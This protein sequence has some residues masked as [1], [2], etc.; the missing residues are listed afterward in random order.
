MQEIE[1]YSLFRIIPVSILAL[2]NSNEDI[3]KEVKSCR[4]EIRKTNDV[5]LYIRKAEETWLETCF[6]NENRPEE[7]L[8]RFSIATLNRIALDLIKNVY[9]HS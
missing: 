8:T 1:F 9:I 7:I 5:S 6:T 4:D 3:C 2:R